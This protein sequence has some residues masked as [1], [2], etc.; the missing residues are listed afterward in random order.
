MAGNDAPQG[1]ADEMN[2]AWIRFIHT[3]DPGWPRFDHVRSTR[4]FDTESTTVPQR[5]TVGLDLLP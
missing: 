3:G 4:L 1:L 5:R 2:G